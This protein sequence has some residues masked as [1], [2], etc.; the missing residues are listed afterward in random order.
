MTAAKLAFLRVSLK[1]ECLGLKLAAYL[2]AL[3]ASMTVDQMAVDLADDLAV[4][5]DDETV[6]G[7]VESLADSLDGMTLAHMSTHV[8]K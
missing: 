1:V 2:V 7:L 6:G 5:L 3:M 8:M 4:N